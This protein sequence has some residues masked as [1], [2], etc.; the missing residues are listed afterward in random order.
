MTPW[1]I[2]IPVKGTPGA[3]SRLAA[4]EDLARAIALDT[5]AV[6]L[7]ARGGSAHRRVVD[8]VIVVTPT[9][10]G[11][12]YVSLGAEIVDDPRAGLE[13]A[14]LAGIAASQGPTAVLLGDLPA[15]EPAELLAAL[16]LAG[17]HARAMVP[18]A[19]GSGTSLITA[20][21][22]RTHRPAFGPGSHALHVA[23]GY[24]E[25]TID[26]S[27]GLRRDVDTPSDLAALAGRWGPRTTAVL[28]ADA[29]PTG[30]GTSPRR[31]MK[32]G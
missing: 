20:R 26:P 29:A 1:T 6:A 21:D 5:V 4:S 3:K 31:T 28:A 16:S 7:E 10:A 19:D 14:I 8:R 15:L 32:H 27:S 11:A 2:V 18:D 30:H 13:A 22:A 17:V 12:A 9:T 24:V 23:A 25:L